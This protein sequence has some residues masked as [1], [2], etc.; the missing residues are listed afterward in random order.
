MAP[1]EIGFSQGL[2]VATEPKAAAVAGQILTTDRSAFARFVGLGR[3]QSH[4]G[5]RQRMEQRAVIRERGSD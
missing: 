2:T 5:H 4:R 1:S 3:L